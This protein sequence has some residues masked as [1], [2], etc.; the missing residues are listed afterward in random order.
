MSAALLEVENLKVHFPVQAGVFR[1]TVG[2]VRAVDGV[3]LRVRAGEV[4]AI[5]G[6]SG[7]GKSTLGLAA[8]GLVTPTAGAIR[9]DGQDLDIHRPASWKPFR[10]KFQII[11]QDPY[12]SL[13][14]RATIFETLA[15][16]LMIHKLAKRAE[17]RDRVANLLAR[18]GL[19]ADYMSRYP[20]AFSGGQRQRLSIARALALE[21]QLIVCDEIV[22]ALDVSVQ[23][24]II[25]LLLELKRELGLALLFISHDLALVRN[26]SDQVNV[27]YLGKIVESGPTALALR[28]PRHPY[29]NALLASIPT[30]QR[31]KKPVALAGEP[32][33]PVNPPSG[34]AFRTRCSRAQ[35][36]CSEETPALATENGI[37]AACFFPIES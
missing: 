35:K 15:E 29:T 28:Q 31:G 22:S 4:A 14:P 7:C 5:V 20:H 3:S 17:L 26:V 1:R 25:N 21:P 18:V 33:S 30:L 6:E 36:R 32:P 37:Q 8:L 19:E 10:R 16:P 11:F 9:L 27:M 23:A 34:C 12:S 2:H 24:Q 13:N